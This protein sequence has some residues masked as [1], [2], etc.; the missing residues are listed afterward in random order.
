M[1]LK[2]SFFQL[3][4]YIREITRGWEKGNG[5]GLVMGDQFKKSLS[6]LVTNASAC[7]LSDTHG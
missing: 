4:I 3:A 5:G 2:I 6:V 1:P 7:A